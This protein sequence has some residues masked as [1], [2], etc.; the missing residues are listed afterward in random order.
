MCAVFIPFYD[1]GGLGGCF[2]VL[3]VLYGV[4]DALFDLIRYFFEGGGGWLSGDVGRGGYDGFSEAFEQVAAE[5]LLYEADGDGAVFVDEV[6]GEADGVFVDD[7][8][9]FSGGLEVVEHAK[10]GAGN[11]LEY[12]A[13]VGQQDDHAF[14][15][16]SLFN[17]VYLFNGLGV[18]GVAADTPDGIGGIEDG[19]AVVK[20]L[21]A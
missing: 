2:V 9:G 4:V 6:G 15:W 12:V 17:G 11:I 21:E 8:G 7:G 20:H 5:R 3:P 16:G 1:G 13:F 19:A 10:V 18:G 14:T